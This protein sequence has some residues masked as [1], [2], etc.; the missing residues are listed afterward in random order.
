MPETAAFID[1][2]RQ[3]FGADCVNDSI[4]KGMQGLPLFH[5]VENGRE[6]GTPLEPL[7]PKSLSAAELVLGDLQ[8]KRSPRRD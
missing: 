2:A 5:A 8:P 1:A 4:R 7:S 3:A 6:F